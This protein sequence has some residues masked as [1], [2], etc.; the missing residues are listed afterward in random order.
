MRKRTPGCGLLHLS[1]LPA[2]VGVSRLNDVPDH[3]T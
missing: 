3:E 1:L 2:A